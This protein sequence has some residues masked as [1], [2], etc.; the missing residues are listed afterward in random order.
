LHGPDGIEKHRIVATRALND[1]LAQADIGQQM[2][3]QR[4]G[5]GDQHDAEH[6]RHQQT[7]HDQVAAQAEGL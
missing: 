4:N 3:H 2:Q 1:V 5:D 6:L 7:G